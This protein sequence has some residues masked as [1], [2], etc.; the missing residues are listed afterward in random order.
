MIDELKRLRDEGSWDEVIELFDA[1]AGTLEVH[2]D[3]V[4][5]YATAFFKGGDA[6]AGMSILSSHYERFRGDSGFVKD[7]A[8]R[9]QDSGNIAEAESLWL[10]YEGLRRD[11]GLPESY[12]VYRAKLH[13]IMGRVRDAEKLVEEGV[14]LF[15]KS[16]KLVSIKAETSLVMLKGKYRVG[17]KRVG[18]SPAKQSICDFLRFGFIPNVKLAR[19]HAHWYDS[20][21]N[22]PSVQCFQPGDTRGA[23]QLLTKIVSDIKMEHDLEHVKIGVTA[24]Y[25]SRGLLGAV[26]DV[27]EEKQVLG[28]TR[29]VE[30]NVDY[31][32]ARLYTEKVLTKHIRIDSSEDGYESDWDPFK[33]RPM[34]FAFQITTKKKNVGSPNDPNFDSAPVFHGYLGD[35]LS[36][37]RLPKVLSA[38]W[39]DA[40]LNFVQRNTPFVRNSLF[41]DLLFPSDYDPGSFLPSS[42]LMNSAV[43]YDD[44]LNLLFRQHQRVRYQAQQFSNDEMRRLAE[45]QFRDKA[46]K[47]RASRICPYMDARWQKSMLQLPFELRNGAAF[48][49]SFLKESYPNIFLDLNDPD[50]KTFKRLKSVSKEEKMKQY[51]HTDWGAMYENNAEFRNLANISINNLA[52]RPGLWFDPRFIFEAIENK[53]EGYSLTLWGLLSLELNLKAGTL[54]SPD[55]VLFND[56]RG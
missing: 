18:M 45:T 28:F 15:P 23:K 44:Q 16:S 31:D 33:N 29:G 14:K 17:E 38:D 27:F 12:Y 19:R 26:L 25:D 46:V 20:I 56:W 53:V 4:R 34:G 5:I 35:A 6:N 52:K 8:I 11:N 2:S 7:F 13:S 36:G 55:A 42:P 41:Y 3:A 32:L 30:G 54:P 21:L 49:H 39:E 47:L 9:Q 10:E 48:Y 50:N 22:D 24:G 43:L 37:K 40:C 1:Y 51:S